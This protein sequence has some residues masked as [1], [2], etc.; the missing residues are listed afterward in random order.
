[1]QKNYLLS[2]IEELL[3]RGRI[4]FAYDDV[5]NAF[6]E[7][8]ENALIQSLS[9]L[10]HKGKIVP[11]YKGFYLIISAEYA[12]RKIIPRRLHLNVKGLTECCVWIE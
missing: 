7:K 6:P 12:N 10:S 8:P 2:W 9:R 4:A 3:A 1:M 11:V 5:K